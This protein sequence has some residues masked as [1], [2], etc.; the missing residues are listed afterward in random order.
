MTSASVNAW[1]EKA[2]GLTGS[3]CVGQADFALEVRRWHG[4]LFD[5]KQRHARLAIE[6]EHVAGL[7]RLRDGIDPTTVV[8]HGDQHRRRWQVAIPQIVV[9]E[10]VVP[11]PFARGR[12]EREQRVGKQVLAVAIAA[13]EVEGR[14]AGRQEHQAPRPVDGD[15]APRIGAAD[16][17]PGVGGPR[18]VAEFARC[19]NGLE[20]PAHATRADVER[21]D[22]ARRGWARSLRQAR[23][24]DEQI[25][26]DRARCVRQHVQLLRAVS[27][28]LF[29]TCAAVLAE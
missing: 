17:R 3:G 14:R 16:V 7:G 15:A 8:G 2:G 21:A 10:L 23:A 4:V 27:E 13:P 6:Q 11:H 20:H 29:Q 9:H 26:V 12:L 25:L 22:V 28:P 19:G 1:R 5:G 18:V 24:D